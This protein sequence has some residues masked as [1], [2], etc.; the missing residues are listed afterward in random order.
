MPSTSEQ[1]KWATEI[2]QLQERLRFASEEERLDLERRLDHAQ[3]R[4]EATSAN[5]A[6]VAYERANPGFADIEPQCS[7]DP[8]NCP[9]CGG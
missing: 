7:G 8:R 2:E 9:K 1:E 6:G 5:N 3:N 4:F